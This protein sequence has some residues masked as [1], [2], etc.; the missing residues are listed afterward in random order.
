LRDAR[1][2]RRLT[3][4]N[5]NR[6]LCVSS[7]CNPQRRTSSKQSSSSTKPNTNSLQETN[8]T[9][10]KNI[11]TDV[12][13][14]GIS[15][16]IEQTQSVGSSVDINEDQERDE[17]IENENE[18]SQEIIDLTSHFR[19]KK[20]NVV[21]V[22]DENVIAIFEEAFQFLGITF[23]KVFDISERK[24]V[25]FVFH[26]NCRRSARLSRTSSCSLCCWKITQSYNR[27]WYFSSVRT[28]SKSC[29]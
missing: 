3:E 6:I 24:N 13:K 22:I 8:I 7:E 20:L 4:L 19:C 16:D 23:L 28:S 5:I 12:S 21:D 1:N 10:A 17:Q 11:V 18:N 27:D 25:N 15:H 29:N 14:N 26:F 2:I 9:N